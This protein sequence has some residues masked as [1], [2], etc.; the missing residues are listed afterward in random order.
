MPRPT[1]TMKAKAER[2]SPARAER[3]G[4][5]HGEHT[6]YEHSEIARAVGD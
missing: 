6:A 2:P 1:Y 3:A 5:P 4:E